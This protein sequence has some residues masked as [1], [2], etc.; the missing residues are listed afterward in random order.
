MTRQLCHEIW[1]EETAA[2]FYFL[3]VNIGLQYLLP[4]LVIII[5]YVLLYAEISRRK[6]PMLVVNQNAQQNQAIEL[7]KTISTESQT[8]SSSVSRLPLNMEYSTVEKLQ[9]RIVEQS[10][11]K[12]LKMLIIIVSLFALSWLPLYILFCIIKF[13]Q[14]DEDSFFGKH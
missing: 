13:T 5:F 10:K 8:E 9:S 14:I 11:L 2:N 6:V 1:P 4:V 7:N 3:V 12:V